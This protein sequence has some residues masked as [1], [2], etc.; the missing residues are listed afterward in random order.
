MFKNVSSEGGLPGGR[1][2]ASAAA[3]GASPAGLG[4]QES[5]WL[6]L[7]SVFSRPSLA[8]VSRYLPAFGGSGSVSGGVMES[9]LLRQLD[10]RVSTLPWFHENSLR[11]L[12]IDA[13]DP[14]AA[15]P[16]PAPSGKDRW[17]SGSYGGDLMSAHLARAHPC[18]TTELDGEPLR[19]SAGTEVPREEASGG[20]GQERGRD[21]DHG[22]YSLEEEHSLGAPHRTEPKEEAPPPPPP[23]QC[24]NLSIAFIMGCPCSDDE[25]DD[26]GQSD[27]DSDDDDD[28]QSDG[29][30]DDIDQ[31][32][33]GS[34]DSSDKDDETARLLASFCRREDPYNPQN[35][36][37]RLHTGRGA[38]P[39]DGVPP[40][41]PG[42]ARAPDATRG[43]RSQP[44]AS[45][46]KVR[47]SDTVQEFLLEEEEDRR[48]PW[49]E[50][51]RDRG[52][53]LRRCREAELVLA[54]CLEPEH[55]RRAYL[56][57]NSRGGSP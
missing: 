26:S 37:A 53:F 28:D 45:V 46:K 34:D 5:S 55:R 51:A 41:A 1:S 23:P 36:S 47:F 22:Y 48:G 20:Q 25:D 39:T 27:F 4:A 15:A 38:P 44:S 3:L 52:R 30:D 2:L 11:Q 31:S 13:V 32:D 18:L 35:F 9:E 56:R 21:Q 7:L 10:A 54:R 49:E 33:V 8:F 24:R 43:H 40:L 12:G 42:K 16:A 14:A 57:L 50:L 17:W 19:E 6:G 29:D